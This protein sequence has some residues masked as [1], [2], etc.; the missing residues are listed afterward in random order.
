MGFLHRSKPSGAFDDLLDAFDERLDRLDQAQLLGLRAAWHAISAETHETA[1]AAVRRVAKAQ[2]FQADVDLI[3]DRA[4]HW[5]TRGDNRPPVYH[6]AMDDEMVNQVRAGAAA[7]IVDAAL[8]MALE[9]WL[10]P[11]AHATLIAPWER[12]V[13]PVP[14]PHEQPK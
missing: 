3:R 14:Q 11:D 7:A 12:V 13:G 8:A 2:Q 1:W 9:P 5:A 6:I 4:M 10:P